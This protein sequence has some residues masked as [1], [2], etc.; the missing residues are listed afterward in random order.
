MTDENQINRILYTN[1]DNKAGNTIIDNDKQY[2][3]I[4]EGI[5]KNSEFKKE[6]FTNFKL[7]EIETT[8]SKILDELLAGFQSNSEI[9][10]EK[11]ENE[12]ANHLI[13]AVNESNLQSINE[14]KETIAT[15]NQG[16]FK[17]E[18]QQGSNLSPNTH[19][20]NETST[21]AD[22]NNAE[23]F[24]MISH[25]NSLLLSDN[26]TELKAVIS[27]HEILDF[28]DFR[29]HHNTA[30][31]YLLLHLIKKQKSKIYNKILIKYVLR[32]DH[33]FNQYV[34][35]HTISN[36]KKNALI[37]MAIE[38][39]N[40]A[41]G[42]E[43]LQL[44]LTRFAKSHVEN[45]LCRI[46]SHIRAVRDLRLFKVCFTTGELGFIHLIYSNKQRTQVENKNL[47]L[48]KDTIHYSFRLSYYH[49]IKKEK[50]DEIIDFHTKKE[51]D[52]QDFVKE[53]EELY[54]KIFCCPV[55]ENSDQSILL[56]NNIENIRKD[57]ILSN[58]NR[59]VC[60]NCNF[61]KP[62]VLLSLKERVC[63]IKYIKRY[64]IKKIH[65]L[66]N[67]DCA[68]LSYSIEKLKRRK[69]NEPKE[70]I[71][72]KV[73]SLLTFFKL[74]NYKYL[75]ELVYSFKSFNAESNN[76]L[77]THF[78]LGDKKWII[79]YESLS[80]TE[81][82]LC[83]NLDSN[84]IIFH[85]KADFLYF[86]HLHRFFTPIFPI[87]Y[88]TKWNTYPESIYLQFFN[89]INC[90][91]QTIMGDPTSSSLKIDRITRI[92]KNYESQKAH[93]LIIKRYPINNLNQIPEPKKYTTEKTNQHIS[94]L[95]PANVTFFSENLEATVIEE[96]HSL[97][98]TVQICKFRNVKH[99]SFSDKLLVTEIVDEIMDWALSQIIPDYTRNSKNLN[100]QNEIDYHENTSSFEDSI[101]KLIPNFTLL[102]K[103]A[104]IT[105]QARINYWI[106]NKL[107]EKDIRVNCGNCHHCNSQIFLESSNMDFSDHLISEN[108]NNTNKPK[109]KLK[110]SYQKLNDQITGYA[111]YKRIQ[112]LQMLLT[113]IKKNADKMLQIN[114]CGLINIFHSSLLSQNNSQ[115][116]DLSVF[117]TSTIEERL[118]YHSF[119]DYLAYISQYNPKLFKNLIVKY[120][121]LFKQNIIFYSDQILVGLEKKFLLLDD[122]L[123]LIL[124]RRDGRVLRLF[125]DVDWSEIGYNNLRN[126]Q[127]DYSDPNECILSNNFSLFTDI[128]QF[129][130][131]TNLVKAFILKIKENILLNETHTQQQNNEL[132]ESIYQINCYLDRI[133]KLVG[134]DKTLKIIKSLM[135]ECDNEVFELLDG[136]IESVVKYM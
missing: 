109:I 110:E 49:Y 74:L 107:D 111:N 12:L 35:I 122:F 73:V 61:N 123:D 75:N 9:N 121:D 91:D 33:A 134:K 22:K 5:R 102:R 70:N 16:H 115:N 133:M 93:K 117:A 112:R 99:I 17:I 78:E 29:F 10:L 94:Y 105:I 62:S 72:S 14:H 65:E 39:V 114:L 92:L 101:S 25:I 56:H 7:N 82:N 31:A 77:F 23:N 58:F 55:E 118:I 95:L 79:F 43:P 6:N 120:K 46:Y 41:F 135:V 59:H 131:S 113:V 52:E 85:D 128:Y 127:S 64:K 104:P 96:I 47:S 86:I 48:I 19:I 81:L 4:N 15:D 36:P 84:P 87:K 30:S 8:S 116:D 24:N 88:D 97:K 103:N 83:H 45:V 89:Q 32:A 26:L 42:Q 13:C 20:K 126:S 129:I 136:F 132:R 66:L 100:A 2:S 1:T 69:K 68:T 125:K 106:S 34:L 80:N 27:N 119:K 63:I 38:I 76:T 3:K 67:K 54:F 18:N 40:F 53:I 50:F 51:F 21:E 108:L 37:L 60:I 57:G 71:T 98:R 44:Q 130:K 28:L 11:Q 124:V 90:I